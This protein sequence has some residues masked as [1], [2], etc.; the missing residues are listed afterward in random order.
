MAWGTSDRKER[1]PGNWLALREEVFRTKGRR[2]YIVE[3]G[4]R[5]TAEATEV[6]HRTA[7]D[8]HSIENL[9]PICSP[10]HRRKSS[11]EGW[12]ELHRKKKATRARVDKQYGWAESRP[13]PT[14]TFKH[15][16][17]R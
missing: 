8:D 11:S 15:P 5:C 10:H 3:D 2:C 17:M 12:V 7:G 1:L 4:Y 14:E 9:E 16:W 13:E 6:D